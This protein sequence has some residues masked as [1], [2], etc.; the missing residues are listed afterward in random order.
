MGPSEPV[1]LFVLQWVESKERVVKS[2]N[3]WT[4]HYNECLRQCTYFIH[5]INSKWSFIIILV[6]PEHKLHESRDF[7][8]T[9]MFPHPEQCLT[10]GGAE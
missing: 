5:S 2:A 6:L 1:T 8:F 9:P 4:E 7:L 3:Y 10:H